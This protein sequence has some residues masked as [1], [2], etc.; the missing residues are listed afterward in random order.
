MKRAVLLAFF[1]AV[2]GAAAYW[3]QGRH[4]GDVHAAW[5]DAALRLGIETAAATGGSEP[6]SQGGPRAGQSADRRGGPGGR[7][8]AP[9]VAVVSAVAQTQDLPITL[10]RLGWIEPI[11]PVTL[12]ARV[13]GEILERMYRTVAAGRS[14]KR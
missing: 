12:R 4:G 5:A 14:P 10:S 3:I 13:D 7:G 2:A 9:R 6:G 11:A 1:I 8:E